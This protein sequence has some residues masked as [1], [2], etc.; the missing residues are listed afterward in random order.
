MTAH[1]YKGKIMKISPQEKEKARKKLLEEAARHFARRGFEEANINEIA[2]GAGYAKG[3]IYNYFR[4]KEELFGEVIAE[5]ARRTIIRYRSAPVY[6]S[7][8]KSLRELALAD[9]SV[10]REEEPFIRVLASE[11]MNPRSDNYDLILTHLGEFIEM[12]SRILDTGIANGEIREDKP[13]PQLALVFLGLLTLLYIQHWKSSGGWPSLDEI[14]D[15]VVT[16]FIDG[17]GRT[18]SE[19]AGIEE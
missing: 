18:G 4:S 19:K 8:R 17:A 11:A 2:T 13:I 1:S 12:I 9:V 15:L 14:P 16:L 5:A 10:L 7:A 6:K 3:T